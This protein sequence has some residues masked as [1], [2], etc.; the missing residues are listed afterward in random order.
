MDKENLLDTITTPLAVGAG[1]LLLTSVL[2][3]DSGILKW[4][5]GS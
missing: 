4:I 2:P 1:T 5:T 3:I